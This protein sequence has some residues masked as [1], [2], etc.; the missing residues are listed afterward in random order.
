MK[1]VSNS[2]AES[3]VIPATRQNFKLLVT[4]GAAYCVS[5]GEKLKEWFPEMKHVTC[6]RY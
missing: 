4:D 5:A 1:F 3:F 2:L 6:I